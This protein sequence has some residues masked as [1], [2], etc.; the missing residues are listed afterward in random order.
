M[1]VD[2]CEGVTLVLLLGQRCFVVVVGLSPSTREGVAV[3]GLRLHS[4][5]VLSAKRSKQ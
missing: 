3:S 4:D 1:T 2:C 5:I